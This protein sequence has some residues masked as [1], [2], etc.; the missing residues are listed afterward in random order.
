MVVVD[1][2]LVRQVQIAATHLYGYRFGHPD[3]WGTITGVEWYKDRPCFV[4]EFD[5][6]TKDRWVIH[7]PHDPYNFRLKPL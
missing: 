3:P 6:G 7:D 4:V 2:R 5:D 1:I